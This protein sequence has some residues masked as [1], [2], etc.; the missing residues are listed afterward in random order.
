LGKINDIRSEA[1]G[2]ETALLL[3]DVK[4]DDKDQAAR[5]AEI[6]VNSHTIDWDELYDRAGAHR[7]R[8]QIA[9][10]I[11]RISSP[12]IP[13]AFRE[14]LD[15][16]CRENL[17]LQLRTIA[18]FTRVKKILD[19]AGIEVVP[20]K[21]FWLAQEFYGDL[22]LREAGDLDLYFNVRDFDRLVTLLIEN[23]YKAETSS[24]PAFIKKMKKISAEFN[25]ERY[26]SG[27][28]VLHAEFHWR[29][30]SGFHGLD[31]TLDELTPHIT[32][33]LIDGRSYPVFTPSANLLLALMHHGGKDPLIRLK[34]FIDMAML[35]RKP[36]ETDPEWVR[37]MSKKFRMER[38]LGVTMILT[39]QITGIN[40]PAIL[41][42]G[43]AADYRIAGERMRMIETSPERWS[44][45]GSELSNLVFHLRTRSNCK[46]KSILVWHSIKSFAVRFFAPRE[47]LRGY[48][49]KRY[50]IE[51]SL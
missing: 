27:E 20:F 41:K 17:S 43:S 29:L 10:L 40:V 14:R 15:D 36:D 28:K 8:P 46:F 24:S 21:G 9:E 30:G 18:E 45:V 3:L 31:I 34:Y 23:G 32:T 37:R 38:L 7:I 6:L 19:E 47:L 12:G 42:G 2:I 26:E 39:E 33:G 13:G 51:R 48:L 25:F 50:G 35:L 49:K 16:Y 4:L 44:A 5:E 22:S 1:G 11:R